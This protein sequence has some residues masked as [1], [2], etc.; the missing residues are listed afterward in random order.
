MN[1]VFLQGGGAKGAFQAGVLCG[2]HDRG[3]KFHVISGTS[4]GAINGYFVLKDAYNEMKEMWLERDI[5]SDGID[6]ESPIIET[7]GVLEFLSDVEDYKDVELLK[8]F[9]VNFVPVVDRRLQHSCAD[10]VQLS[11]CE[12]FERIRQSSLLP[13]GIGVDPF[14]GRY[15][16]QDASEQFAKDLGR[17][18]YD[19]F[20]LDG[21]LL[22]NMFLEPFK[23]V[24][25][26]KL[27]IIVFKRD[28]ELPSYIL[29]RYEDEALCVIK[30]D[31]QYDKTDTMNF[32]HS[33]LESNF[34]RGYEIAK[35][36]SI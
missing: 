7:S 26:D 23:D 35:A 31:I 33:F 18:V 4:I 19:D 17:G 2:L 15:S 8:H 11:E 24:T 22:N 21:G 20:V 10:L 16:L 9:Y 27:F 25:V 12:R 28:F 32:K 13:K 30:S 14:D 1:G 29:E 5:S 3:V 34:K 6:V 36:I